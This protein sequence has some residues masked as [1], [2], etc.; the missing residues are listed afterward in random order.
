M[1]QYSD[2]L[3]E[4]NSIPLYNSE[5][6]KGIGQVRYTEPFHNYL[7]F[8]LNGLGKNSINIIFSPNPNQSRKTALAIKD[9]YPEINGKELNDLIKY[10]EYSVHPK[11]DLVD[12]LQRGVA[13]HNGRLPHHVRRVVERAINDRIINNIVCTTTLMQGVNLP[14][15]NVI[16]RNPNLFIQNRENNSPKLS[17][18]EFANLRGRAGRLLKDFIGRTY[19]LDEASFEHDE[20][21]QAVFLKIHIKN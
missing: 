16:I 8:I 13:Y 12:T 15:Q 10:I 19:I 3:E 1:R 18:Y 4:P 21:E 17:N 2:V 20:V 6:I 9:E 7:K 14:A 11:Y 5:E